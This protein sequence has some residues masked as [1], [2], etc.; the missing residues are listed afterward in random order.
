MM[1]RVKSV[2]ALLLLA[3]LLLVGCGP[4]FFGHT[5]IDPAASA[6]GEVELSVEQPA[7]AVE[8]EASFVSLRHADGIVAQLWQVQPPNRD[9]DVAV[10]A[11]HWDG[12]RWIEG[13]DPAIAGLGLN[14]FRF[15]WV[16]ELRGPSEQATVPIEAHLLPSWTG[17]GDAPGP[18]DTDIGD[19]TLKIVSIYPVD[20]DL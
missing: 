1:N 18:D 7:M 10:Y 15:R 8:F 16:V 20:T 14:T 3:G 17:G 9:A 19:A 6:Q 4:P 2:G 11:S 13:K 5:D 12:E